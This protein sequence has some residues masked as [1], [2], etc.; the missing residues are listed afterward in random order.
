MKKIYDVRLRFTIYEIKI[1]NNM[2]PMKRLFTILLFGC[3][4]I[5]M[6]QNWSPILVNEKMNYQHS[7]S[8]YI[9]HTIW[10]DS[11]YFPYY[12][13]IYYLNRIVKDVPENPEVVLRNQPQF[14]LKKMMK[15]PEG[16]YVFQFPGEMVIKSL[17]GIADP[18]YF[19]IENEM[20][21]G[22]DSISVE[23]IFGVQDSVKF[24]TLSD[25]SEIWLS[26]TFGIIKFPDFE[27]GGYYELVGI[28]N[29]EYGESVPDF[30]DIF[31][32]EIGDVQQRYYLDSYPGYGNTF[33]VKIKI[34]SKEIF[35]D[36]ITYNVILLT[37]FLNNNNYIDVYTTDLNFY[38]EDHLF[39]NKFNNELILLEDYWCSPNYLDPNLYTRI[40]FYPDSLGVLTKKWGTNYGITYEELF[41][42]TDPSD[43]TLIKLGNT[44]CLSEPEPHGITYA[45]SL[46]TT[47]WY[48]DDEV[49]M[50]DYY[51]MMGYVKG[52]DTVGTVWSDSIMMVGIESRQIINEYNF[53][54]S[55]N[56]VKDW[57]QIKLVDSF[58]S[59]EFHIE[60]RNLYGQLV[61]KETDI[62]SSHYTMNVSDLKAGVYFYMI[63]EKGEVVQLGKLIKK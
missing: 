63:K 7:D 17:A 23:E 15:Y 18:W 48:Y 39:T 49:E 5:L 53:A 16:N 37:R 46:G 32:F 38:F 24:I 44:E 25:Y 28:Q 58:A 20:M 8:S 26:K 62:Q 60:I 9:N 31:D 12:D 59:V 19:D 43:D 30:W 36:H 35:D 27:N 51:Y 29:T 45:E 55:P 42:E 6:A 40:S 1:P 11:A 47:L 14:L 56:P 4:S 50:Q 57:L 2:K 54:I 34:N 22:V 41:Y 3:S 52:G 33:V 13:S 21:A 10:V 61:R